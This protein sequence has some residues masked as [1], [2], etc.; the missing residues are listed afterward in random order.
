MAEVPRL[1]AQP[2]VVGA[3]CAA[4]ANALTWHRAVVEAV[5]GASATVRMVD[6]GT[7]E[8]VQA[9]SL[10]QLPA[11][12][13]ATPLQAVQV[14]LAKTVPADGCSWSEPACKRFRELS[15]GV[16]VARLVSS[17]PLAMELTNATGKRVSGGTAN[18]SLPVPTTVRR[19]RPRLTLL[20]DF[21]ASATPSPPR[22]SSRALPN[23]RRPRRHH[24]RRKK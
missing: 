8:V 18:P 14:S 22:L 5:E 23:L 9:S 21:R 13:Y 12:C 6:R 15:K 16:L 10:R 19:P 1:V 17:A 4:C 11:A 24:K 7:S 20:L 2:P 3:V